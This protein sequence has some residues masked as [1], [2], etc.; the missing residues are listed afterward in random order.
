MA[1]SLLRKLPPT[2]YAAY[3]AI[4]QKSK[5]LVKAKKLLNIIVAAIRLLFLKEI[6][7]TLYIKEETHTLENLEFQ[8]IEQL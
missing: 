8:E 4:L 5:D 7:V 3:D 6:G 1:I 2:I